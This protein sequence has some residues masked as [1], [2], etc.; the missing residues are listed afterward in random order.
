[1]TKFRSDGR[2]TSATDGIAP[3]LVLTTYSIQ[4]L[5]VGMMVGLQPAGAKDCLAK[6]LKFVR[7]A[8]YQALPESVR[9]DLVMLVKSTFAFIG[10]RTSDGIERVA[11]NYDNISPSL[12]QLINRSSCLTSA[13]YCSAMRKGA[14][15]VTKNKWKAWNTEMKKRYI[16]E[17]IT[18]KV[19]E[20]DGSERSICYWDHFF[21]GHSKIRDHVIMATCIVTSQF[22]IYYRTPIDFS[23]VRIVGEDL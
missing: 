18:D 6:S 13:L 15:S 16:S 4:V 7:D 5:S 2:Y 17:C 10:V 11:E 1:M 19:Q 9:G 8:D 14:S 3:C 23:I 22:T 20:A 12:G 21:D